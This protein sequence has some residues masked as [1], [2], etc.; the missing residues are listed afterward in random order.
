MQEIP[1]NT[2]KQVQD[3]RKGGTHASNAA[4][5]RL[6]PPRHRAQAGLPEQPSRDSDFGRVIHEALASGNTHSL[7]LQQREVYDNC[8]LIEKKFIQDTFGDSPVFL[9]REQRFYVLID[10]KY[11]HSG[12][13]DLV[14]RAGTKGLIIEYKTLPGDVPDAPDNEQLRDQVALA[15]GHL[16]LDEVITVVDQPGVTMNPVPCR[17]TKAD[18]K[19]AEAEMFERVRRCYDPTLE[20]NPGKLQC[21]H[22]LAKRDCLPYMRWAGSMVPAMLTLLDVPVSQWTPEQRGIFCRQYHVAKGWLEGTREAMIEGAKKDPKF[23]DGFELKPGAIRTAILDP[24]S[25]FTRYLAL[26]G[27]PQ[28]FMRC[29][30]VGMTKLREAINDLTG[31]RGKQL[32]AAMDTLLKGLTSEQQNEPSLRPIDPAKDKS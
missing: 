3:E 29:V 31:A 20:R 24:Q 6:C 25:V 28:K 5:D 30:A 22:C 2:S 1:K 7:S 10:G 9:F 14:V 18:I 8:R 17:Y 23:I 21:E 19:R 27:T 26:G 11:F 16:I 13:P 32:D 12:K 15:A 4:A